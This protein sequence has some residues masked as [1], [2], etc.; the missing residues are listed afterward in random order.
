MACKM[1]NHNSNLK[2]EVNCAMETL[3]TWRGTTAIDFCWGPF[4]AGWVAEEHVASARSSSILEA[5]QTPHALAE[6]GGKLGRSLFTPVL[7]WELAG[8]PAPGAFLPSTSCYQSPGRGCLGYFSQHKGKVWRQHVHTCKT[9]LCM[10][11]L[12]A[13]E[14]TG[15]WGNMDFPLASAYC[16]I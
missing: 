3:W 15:L 14:G 9:S 10:Y 8:I 16:K 6:C 7:Q 2:L 12:C 11:S 4:K 13:G 1:Q 5:I